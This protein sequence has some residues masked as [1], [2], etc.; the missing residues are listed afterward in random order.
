LSDSRLAKGV[1]KQHRALETT[2][3]TLIRNDF[4]IR[5]IEEWSPA[6]EQIAANPDLAEETD[7][8]MFLFVAAHR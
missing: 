3:N 4:A 6:P 7:R 8:P 5:H 1:M 2:L